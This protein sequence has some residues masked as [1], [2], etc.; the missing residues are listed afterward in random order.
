ME[1]DYRIDLAELAAADEL[2][3]NLMEEFELEKINSWTPIHW[4][5]NVCVYMDATGNIR[6]IGAPYINSQFKKV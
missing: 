6:T 3:N 4:D 5:S 1:Y 2:Y